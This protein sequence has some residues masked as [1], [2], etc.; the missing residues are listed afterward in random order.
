MRK[1]RR[2]YLPTWL[3]ASI[4]GQTTGAV[5][6]DTLGAGAAWAFAVNLAMGCAQHKVLTIDGT[7]HGLH[8]SFLEGLWTDILRT[9]KKKDVRVVATTHSGDAIAA[10]ARAAAAEQDQDVMLVRLE[11][12]AG[13]PSAVTYSGDEL[14]TAARQGIEVR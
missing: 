12:G 10:L 11:R 5:Y 1:C 6:V 7:E 14:L 8:H 2:A 3:A 13:P 9:S 4:T